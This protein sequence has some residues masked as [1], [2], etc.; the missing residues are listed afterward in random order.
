MRAA[1]Q[2]SLA[3]VVLVLVSAIPGQAVTVT[4]GSLSVTIR[5]DNGAIDTVFFGGTDFCNPAI[6]S[7]TGSFRPVR[8]RRHS[9]STAP[10]AARGSGQQ[11]DRVGGVV[12]AAGTYG[13]VGVTRECWIVPG[14]D[15]LRTRTTLTNGGGGSAE[16]RWSTRSTQT[17]ESGL[18]ETSGP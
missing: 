5:D 4:N 3:V 17:R 15:V 6:R 9:A 11:R 7:R 1:L 8:I 14:V 12:T 2:V 16:L 10:V 18:R 13:G